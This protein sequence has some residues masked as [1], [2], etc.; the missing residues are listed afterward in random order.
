ML[1]L[2]IESATPR[3]LD[4]MKKGI[5]LDLASKIVENLH[6][7]GIRIYGYFLFGLPTESGEE[8]LAT[9]DWIREHGESID[10]LNL[11]LMNFPRGGEM[12]ARPEEFGVAAV[13]KRDEAHDLSLY[14]EYGGEKTLER[15]E[16]RRILGT[17]KRDPKIRK[18]I[19]QTPPGFTSNHAAFAPL[20]LK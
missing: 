14:L 17:A 9:V 1:Q 12:E 6:R 19:G 13:S 4:L 16:L 3:L 11:S 2:G 7:A 10:F 15:R 18:L 5:D 8:A 20:P